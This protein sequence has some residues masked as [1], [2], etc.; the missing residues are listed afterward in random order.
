MMSLT[1][2]CGIFLCVMISF[3]FKYLMDTILK[4]RYK[5]TLFI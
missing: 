3:T 1:R 4:N 2:P 5:G